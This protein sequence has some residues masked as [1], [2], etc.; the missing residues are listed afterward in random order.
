MKILLSLPESPF[1]PTNGAARSMRTIAEL[2]VAAGH[3]VR[4]VATTAREH[5]CDSVY[6]TRFSQRGVSYSIV[7]TNGLGSQRWRTPETELDFDRRFEAARGHNP[8]LLLC[9]GGHPTDQKRYLRAHQSGVKIV[10][11]LR[12]YGYGQRGWFD[13]FDGIITSSQFLTNWYRTRFGV[14]STPLPLP[15]WPEDVIAENPEPKYFMAINPTREKGMMILETVFGWLEKNRPDIPRMLI[16]DS[17]AHMNKEAFWHT[18]ILRWQSNPAEIYR[19]TK[20]LLVPSVWEEPAGRV[21]AEAMLNGIPPIITDRGGM[22]E[23]ANGGAIILPLDKRITTEVSVAHP[24]SMKIAQPWIDM[25]IRLHD[26]PA[27]YAERSG[28]AADAAMM[29]HTPVT[30]GL[31]SDYFERILAGQPVAERPVPIHSLTALEQFST[32]PTDEANV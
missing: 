19:Q 8:D 32:A 15:I 7:N 10:F 29:Y 12:N 28:I 13:K 22:P 26:D 31:Y 14:E 25:I 5:G 16:T 2:M 6:D 17:P 11:G 9:Y 20:V 30:T 3:N 4:C 27:Y 18:Q 1:D 24:V 23:V 21:I